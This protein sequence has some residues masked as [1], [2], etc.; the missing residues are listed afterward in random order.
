MPREGAKEKGKDYG[1]T[2]TDMPQQIQYFAMETVKKALDD[3]KSENESVALVKEAF[4]RKF[5]PTWHCILGR[6][7]GSQVTHESKTFL[8]VTVN[9]QLKMLL[10]KS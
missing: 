10:F 6:N 1:A 3:G 8:Y 5:G 2:V 4:D 7:F 9:K